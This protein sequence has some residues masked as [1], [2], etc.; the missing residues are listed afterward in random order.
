M[1]KFNSIQLQHELFLRT[2][3]YAENV[4]KIYRDYLTKVIM[5]VRNVEL[6]PDIPFSFS[7]Y[8]INGANDLFREMYS[9]VYQEIRSDIE[10]E[11]YTSNAN[12]DNLVKSVFGNSSIEDHH[13][14]R[15]FDRNM[16]A[17][18][19]FFER[20]MTNEGLNLSQRVWKYV[21]QY[22]DELE[23]TLDL[24]MGEGTGANKLASKVQEYLQDPDRFYRRFR[25]A[26]I[27]I[28]NDG[29]PIYE[30]IWKRRVFDQNSKTYTWVNDSPENY[31]PGRGVYRSSYRNAQ[32]LVRTETNIAYRTADYERW[33]HL[34]FIV[35]VEIRLSN[36]HPVYDICDE[37]AGRYPK[38]F[39]WTG[40]HPNC[41]CYM[42]PVMANREEMDD[43][44]DQIM[45]DDTKA[46]SSKN[47]ILEYPVQFKTWVINNKGRMEQAQV[48][49]TLPYFV[50]D[51][52]KS[53]SGMM[54]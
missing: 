37:L 14:A 15:Y 10:K 25:G 21:A 51:N 27:G 18:D 11:W 50:K 41:R 43:L 20:K 39:K 45:S 33:A 2:E 1:A 3:G 12:N 9:K 28:D 7:E 48:N 36:N 13:F 46:F 31:N 22:K 17:M 54:G 4:R 53:I 6:L 16:N 24:A 26:K 19:A 40:W 5:L 35:G 32:R 29:K 47:E 42:I 8:E 52:F 34:D 44:I 23:M 30:R 38:D 49:G